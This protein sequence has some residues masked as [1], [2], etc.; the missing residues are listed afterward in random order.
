ML[1][2]ID[3]LLSSD[4]KGFLLLKVHSLISLM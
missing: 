2:L 3:V 1:T 4:A